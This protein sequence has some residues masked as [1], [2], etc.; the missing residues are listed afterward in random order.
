MFRP[1]AWLLATVALC[2]PAFGQ[3]EKPKIVTKAVS[4]NTADGVELQGTLYNS[5]KGAASPCVML[6]HSLGKNPNEGDWDGLALMLADKGF[7]VLRFDF[8]GHGKSFVVD[9]KKFWG[10]QHGTINQRYMPQLAAKNPLPVRLDYKDFQN[11]P[12]YFPQLAN[13][14]LAARYFLDQEND[15]GTVNTS[16]V[17]LIGA[18]DAAT[19]GMIY[20]TAEWQRPKTKP[21]AGNLSTLP[22][23]QNELVGTNGVEPAGTDVAG[24]IWLSASLHSSM[25]D[26][27]IKKLPAISPDLRDKNPMWFLYGADDKTNATGMKMSQ[28]FY[29]TVLQSKP[30]AMSK[31]QPLKFNELVDIK[32]TKNVGVNLLGNKLG[33]EEK[34]VDFLEKIEKD[35]KSPARVPNRGYTAPPL[36]LADRYGGFTVR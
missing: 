30:P 8:R 6:L 17:Y 18:T 14:I 36:L 7:T 32:G 28:Y 35:R 1:L 19:I 21:L 9:A 27:S 22:P 10:N 31:L 15:G 29:Q 23:P 33:T 26:T 25:P 3:A 20:M 11:K 34:I 12:G 13:D 24:A 16:S 5:S 2:T 4:F